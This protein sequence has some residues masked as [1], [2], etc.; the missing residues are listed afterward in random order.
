MD[1]NRN[2]LREAI[3]KAV[4]NALLEAKQ[5]QKQDEKRLDTIVENVVSKKLRTLNEEEN[6]ANKR[7]VVLQWLRQDTVNVA[8]V[9]RELEGEP[10]TQEEEDSKRSYF[11]KKVYE[12]DGKSF[13]DD[14][15]NALYAIKSKLGQ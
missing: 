13:S 11:M 6:I 15:I 4:R 1:K 7:H 9:R 10:E 2:I 8:A 3:N 12:T 14:E 5:K